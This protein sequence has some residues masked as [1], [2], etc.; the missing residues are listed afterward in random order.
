MYWCWARVRN[1]H[2]KSIKLNHVKPNSSI[3]HSFLKWLI[4]FTWVLFS[5]FLILQSCKKKETVWNSNWSSPLVNDTL[6]INEIANDSTVS[7]SNSGGFTLN[8]KKT[9]LDINL[10]DIIKFPDTTITKSITVAFSNFSVEPGAS[11]AN[12]TEE[13]TINIPNVE[14]KKVR[15]SKGILH[16][17]FQNTVKTPV[18]YTILLPGV[19]NNGIDFQEI[20][21]VPAATN[22]N[23]GITD[24]SLNLEGYELDL[25]GISGTG[26]NILQSK[27]IVSTDPNGTE[28]AV[29]DSKIAD[30]AL[31]L[32]NV[33]I[34]YAKGYFGNQII[35]DTIEKS[36]DF[37]SKIKAGSVNL[38]DASLQ[39]SIQNGVNVPAQAIITFL[40]NKKTN[41]LTVPLSV[42]PSNSFQFSTPFSIDPA[43]A[44]WST[45][46][47]SNKTLSFT[48]STSNLVKYLENLGETQSIGY[49]IQLNPSGNSTTDVN[50]LFPTSKLKITMDAAIPLTIGLNGLTLQNKFAFHLNQNTKKTHLTSG[51]LILQATNAFPVSGKISL[52]FL[53]S[54]GGSLFSVNGS[55]EISSSLMG[56]TVSS[57]GLKTNVSIVHFAFTAEMVTKL[58]LA[59]EVEITS[60]FST[61]DALSNSSTIISIPEGAFLGIKLKGDFLIEN[62]Y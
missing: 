41:G 49:S 31:E 22:S 38:S 51:G 30:L 7:F 56:T 35:S 12:S 11:F 44:S 39:L 28:T 1:D 53:D 43:T 54:N 60:V 42:T 34:D 50:E 55:E 58:A 6:S 15:L 62:K 25:T 8:Y 17:T 5:F 18:I 47:N 26:F 14:L 27:F 19:T 61:P 24:V 20:V 21:T 59:N 2:R 40:K 52:R 16:V 45:I 37:L 10:S 29:T 13:Y 9:I 48:S 57:K 4:Q 36:L 23:I 46:S 32:K 33:Q 3:N